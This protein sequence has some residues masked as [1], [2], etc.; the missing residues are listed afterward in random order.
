MKGLKF[1]SPSGKA[2]SHMHGSEEILKSL[3]L[4]TQSCRRFSLL[5]LKQIRE[6]LCVLSVLATILPVFFLSFGLF[7]HHFPWSSFRIRTCVLNSESD[8][9]YF[10]P[11]TG[12]ILFARHNY[13][14]H[15]LQSIGK[16][17]VERRDR[18]TIQSLISGLPQHWAVSQHTDTGKNTKAIFKLCYALDSYFGGLS[19]AIMKPLA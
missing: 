14:L 12:R 2:C 16:L 8:Y 1:C 5:G 7:R 9:M 3:V 4:T 19:S 11:V 18:T 15:G 10:L 6:H 13:D 17:D